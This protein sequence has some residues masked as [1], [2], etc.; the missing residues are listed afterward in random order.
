[1]LRGG[2]RRS[3]SERSSEM[4]RTP[5]E[6]DEEIEH[7][8]DL[9]SIYTKNLRFTEKQIAMFASNLVPIHLLNQRD[10]FEADRTRALQIIK[11]LTEQKGT[12]TTDKKPVV[13]V[14]LLMKLLPTGVLHLYSHDDL[15]I[16]KYDL[17][18]PSGTP[19]AVIISSWIENFSYTRSD[20]IHL[21]PGQRQTVTQ[22]P[23]LK[24]DEIENIY[25]VRK[26][27]LHTRASYIENGQESLLFIQD[28]DIQFLA[29]D[30]ITWA[31]IVDEET[32]H[33]LSYQIA[34][35]VT[36]N[37]RSVVEM[38][39]YA[40]DYLPTGLLWGYHGANTTEERSAIVQAQIKAI[41]EA[42]KHKAEIKYTNAPISFGQR[43]NE[44]RQRVSLP[45]DSLTSRQANCIDGAVL[46]A[47]LI[48]RAA[49]HPVIV[50]I[51]GHAFVGWETWDGSGQYE[52]LETIMTGSSSFDE[53]LQRG[54][55][56]FNMVKSLVGHRLFDPSG[57]AVLLNLADLRKREILPM[58]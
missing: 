41:F 3:R 8:R 37:A 34:A 20:T 35:W 16:L 30:V 38:L 36:P 11:D 44:V 26:G 31:I 7:Q 56:E 57:F 45:K 53:A 19:V 6:I 4:F 2:L 9:L 28:Y 15:P 58:E 25:E 33:D 49:L 17:A 14:Q 51:P 21:A 54:A 40:A 42:L 5:E 50:F 52:Y 22:L 12:Y 27:V 43:A 10:A 24:L 46:Y 55:D 32:V 48:E 13:A 1:M 18:N 39:R 47:S 23:T 29:R